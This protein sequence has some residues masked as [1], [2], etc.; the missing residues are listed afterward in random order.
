MLLDL[1]HS[2]GIS[3]V[4]YYLS[5]VRPLRINTTMLFRVILVVNPNEFMVKFIKLLILTL[6]SMFLLV[7]FAL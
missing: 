1:A 6:S 7:L 5:I 2:I 3:M 4:Q